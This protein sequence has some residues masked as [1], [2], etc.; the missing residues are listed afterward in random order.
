MVDNI[1]QEHKEI[2]NKTTKDAE[3]APYPSVEETYQFVYDPERYG[4]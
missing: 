2:I 4:Q 1:E 3:K